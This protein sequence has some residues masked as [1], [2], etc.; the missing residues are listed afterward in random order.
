[1]VCLHILVV[2]GA[3]DLVQNFG[4]QSQPS[5]GS[6]KAPMGS[7]NYREEAERIVADE[8]AQNEKMPVYEVWL[9]HEILCLLILQ[10]LEEFRLVEKMGD[11]AFSNVYKAVERKT[12]RKVAVKVVRKF[13]LNS[14]QVRLHLL[15]FSLLLLLY[16]VAVLPCCLPYA[17]HIRD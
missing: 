17:G 14:S 1:M 5:N 11:G 2:A 3:E 9:P 4:S 15:F 7:P 10:G 6:S 12:G 16:V 8:K 13:E